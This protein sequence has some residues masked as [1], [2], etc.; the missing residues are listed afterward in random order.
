MY[1]IITSGVPS[2]DPLIVGS[3]VDRVIED[4][5]SEA[6]CCTL[7]ILKVWHAEISVLFW[8]VTRLVTFMWEILLTVVL[9]CLRGLTVVLDHKSLPPVFKSLRGHIWRLFHLW[10]RFVT[11]GG[12]SAQLPYHVHRSGHKTSTMTYSV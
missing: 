12:C 6:F 5:L 11:F 10:L 1:S 2:S 4:C 9:G 8:I 7:S 3:E